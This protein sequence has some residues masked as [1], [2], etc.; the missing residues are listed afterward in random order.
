M[1]RPRY[2][3]FFYSHLLDDDVAPEDHQYGRLV[4]YEA[5]VLGCS[6]SCLLW[7]DPVC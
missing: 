3:H 4:A 5:D 6:G 2:R 7:G 1:N